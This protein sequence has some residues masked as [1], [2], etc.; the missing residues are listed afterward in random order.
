MTENPFFKKLL[1][2]Q[3]SIS[4]PNSSTYSGRIFVICGPTA[5]GKGTILKEVLTRLDHAWYS[6]SATTRDARP[7]EINGK[8]YYFL[9]EDEF[10]ALVAAKQM[11]EWATVHKINRY[12]TPAVPVYEAIAAGKTVI[13]EL[14]LA[15]AR[16]VRK[17]MPDVP[18][19]F[20]APPSWEELKSRLVGRATESCE[21]QER[22][23]NTAKCEIAAQ[24]EFDYVVINDTVAN[25]TAKILQ[26][27]ADAR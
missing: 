26:I 19:I 7:G 23:L 12:G 20:V 24:N 10:S 11:L 17:S 9:S 1:N 18:Q 8:H 16:Q 25:A 4:I 15:G 27:I 22:R 14:D 5:V 21:E 6:V 13:L 2:A 3:Q